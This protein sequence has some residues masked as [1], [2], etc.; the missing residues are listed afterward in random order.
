[1]YAAFAYR[2][3]N[4]YIPHHGGQASGPAIYEK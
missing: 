2:Q 1:M 4:E 3:T